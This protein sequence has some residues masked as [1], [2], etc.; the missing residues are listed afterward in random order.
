MDHGMIRRTIKQ[1]AKGLLCGNMGKAIGIS[2]IVFATSVVLNTL[3]NAYGV[4]MGVASPGDVAAFESMTDTEIIRQIAGLAGISLISL[5]AALLLMVPLGYGQLGWYYRLTQGESLGISSLF[6]WFS[7]GKK[8][9]KCLRVELL[10]TL[11]LILL[12]IP[13]Y[14]VA[15]LGGALIGIGAVW[16]SEAAVNGWSVVLIVVGLLIAAAAIVLACIVALRYYMVQYYAVRCPDWNL[17]EIFRTAVR[18]MRGHRWEA[19]KFELSFLGWM[20]LVPFTCGL[21]LLWLV[22]Y[23]NAASVLFFNYVDD[24]T[25]AAANMQVGAEYTVE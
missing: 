23:I 9:G 15:I 12:L 14:L 1:N 3:A 21:I 22:P 25:A 2:L 5:V 6:D 20:L 11:K 19:I 17:K 7:S 18:N 16:V 10:Y 8:Y 13:V 4:M 24:S